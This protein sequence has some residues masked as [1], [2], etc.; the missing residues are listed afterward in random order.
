MVKE[1]GDRENNRNQLSTKGSVIVTQD[2]TYNILS[3][4]PRVAR[5]IYSFKRY[6][7]NV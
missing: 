7:E 2:F 4:L 6:L 5:K 3:N 1:L